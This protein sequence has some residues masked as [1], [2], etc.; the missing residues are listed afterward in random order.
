[1]TRDEEIAWA[2]AIAKQPPEENREALRGYGYSEE[3]IDD[4]YREAEE[5]AAK[6]SAEDGEG[7]LSVLGNPERGSA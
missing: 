1:M 2:R 3:E 7:I 5:I 4:L 6:L